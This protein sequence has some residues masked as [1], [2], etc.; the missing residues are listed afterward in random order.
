MAKCLLFVILKYPKNSIVCVF[1]VLQ[2]LA[3][4][5]ILQIG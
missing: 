3:S 2:A 5:W 1:F 4:F